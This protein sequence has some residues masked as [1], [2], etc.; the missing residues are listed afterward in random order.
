[1]SSCFSTYVEREEGSEKPVQRSSHWARWYPLGTRTHAKTIYYCG[2]LRTN[3]HMAAIWIDYVLCYIQGCLKINLNFV[4]M[5]LYRKLCSCIEEMWGCHVHLWL[6]QC[7]IRMREEEGGVSVVVLSYLII[8]LCLMKMQ[9]STNSPIT[10]ETKL[11]LVRS[12]LRNLV[13]RFRYWW[14]VK[15]SFLSNW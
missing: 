15:V 10:W 2:V 8:M 13:Y 11:P 3:I 9:G 6:V 12:L 14:D 7:W 5:F 1:M 4:W